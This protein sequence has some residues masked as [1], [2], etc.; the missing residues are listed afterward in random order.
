MIP[1]N[2]CVFYLFLLGLLP[3]LITHFYTSHILQEISALDNELSMTYENAL[4]KQHSERFNKAIQKQF[5]G[6]DHFYIDNE[7][8]K[9]PLLQ[10][11]IANLQQSLD[12]GFHSH[13]NQIKQRLLQ[14]TNGQNKIAFAE[15]PIKHYAH[16]NE[17]LETMAKP[18]EVDSNDLALILSR[19]EGVTIGSNQPPPKRPHLIIS[20]C[21]LERKKGPIHE[22]FSLSLKL[23][24]REYP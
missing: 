8:E 23:I 7:I 15:G 18:V 16:F 17:T 24:K 19:I 10:N 2:R 5:K 1:F 20:D 13:E 22:S 3:L 14:L 21:K 4:K 11:E 12:H 9:I 6:A